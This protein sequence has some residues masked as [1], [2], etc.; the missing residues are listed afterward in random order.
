[1]DKLVQDK[2][3]SM[4]EIPLTFIP[5]VTTTVPST[6]AALVATTI[7]IAT[8]IST[9]ATTSATESSIAVAH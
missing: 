3:A 5:V 2:K 6:S 1:M 8:A 4:E 7:P 9:S